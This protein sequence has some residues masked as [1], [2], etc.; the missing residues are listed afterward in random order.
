[1]WEYKG[2]EGRWKEYVNEKG[3]STIAEHK[4]K[5]IWT[6]CKDGK[7]SWRYTG[8]PDNNRE[9]ECEKCHLIRSFI[10]GKEMLVDGQLVPVKSS[11]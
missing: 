6:S 1:M 10:L 3:E 11:K 9:I 7:H 5:T 8:N 4:P 2:G